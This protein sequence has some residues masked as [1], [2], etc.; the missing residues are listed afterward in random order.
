MVLKSLFVVM[1]IVGLVFATWVVSLAGLASLQAKCSATSYL[2]VRG[3]NAGI[4]PCSKIYRYYWFIVAF[5]FLLICGL[6][7]STITGMLRKSRLS[8]LGLFAVATLLYIQATDSFLTAESIGRYKHGQLKHRA[9][10]ATAGFLMTAIANILT[11]VAL[12]LK[13]NK[14]G[15][16]KDPVHATAV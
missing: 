4:L 14:T 2:G 13:S 1:P 3:F 7:L 6:A 8:W 5:E 9:R 12:G 11:V 10:T 16:A 15:G